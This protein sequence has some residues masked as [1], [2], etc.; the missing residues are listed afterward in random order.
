MKHSNEINNFFATYK[1]NNQEAPALNPKHYIIDLNSDI[2]NSMDFGNGVLA[3]KIERDESNIFLCE[4]VERSTNQYEGYIVKR[5]VFLFIEIA[6][7][8]Q[9]KSDLSFKKLKEAKS[10]K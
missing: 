2:I 4:K 8:L 10:R 1:R 5:N 7:Q 6:N 9:R 3:V